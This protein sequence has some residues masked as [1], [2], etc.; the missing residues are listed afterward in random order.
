MNQREPQTDTSASI[1]GVV[2]GARHACGAL[3]EGSTPR[4]GCEIQLYNACE[5]VGSR[6]TDAVG[7]YQFNH[8]IPGPYVVRQKVEPGWTQTFPGFQTRFTAGCVTDLNWGYSQAGRVPPQHWPTIAP[9][10]AGDFQS[11]VAIPGGVATDLRDVLEI[12][13][14][15]VATE[16][17]MNDG[18]TIQVRYPTSAANYVQAGGE[19][20]EFEQ[21]HFH[22]PA[23]HLIDAM[24]ADMELHLVHRHADGGLVVIGVLLQAVGERDHPALGPVFSSLSGLRHRGDEG[25]LPLDIDAGALLPATL[26]GFFYTGSLTTPPASQSVSWFVLETPVAISQRQLAAYQAIGDLNDFNPGNR[27]VQPLNGRRFNEINHE[28][29]LREGQHVTAD[30]VNVETDQGQG[31]G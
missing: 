24:L 1:S 20:F 26:T 14:R 5:L 12:H 6:R 17:I 11:P 3:G 29:S 28:I 22:T 9:D 2:Y 25:T 19:K 15:P 30:F 31:R 13:Y 21:F 23:E 18:H 10:A 27:P 8:L 4:T 16:K 7:Q